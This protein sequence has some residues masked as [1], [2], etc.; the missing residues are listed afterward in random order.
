MNQFPGSFSGIEIVAMYLF[1]L[2][3]EEG[4]DQHQR[5]ALDRLRAILYE[6]LSVEDLEDL[7]KYYASA[8]IEGAF[9]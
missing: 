3:H 7:D 5:V 9:R 4:L 2:R 8:L 6:N 1:L